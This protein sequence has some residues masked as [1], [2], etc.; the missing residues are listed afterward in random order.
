MKKIILLTI[1][2]MAKG[3]VFGQQ[4]KQAGW[5]QE[6]AYFIEEKLMDGGH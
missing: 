4:N 1:L 2:F 6:V 3:P 5:Q